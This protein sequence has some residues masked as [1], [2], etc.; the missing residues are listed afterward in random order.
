MKVFGYC[1]FLCGAFENFLTFCY[2]SSG[3]Y[4]GALGAN[5]LAKGLEGNKSL[6][7]CVLLNLAIF[8]VYFLLSA[9]HRSHY[10]L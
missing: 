3:N 2:H 1:I 9:S 5:A 7:V 8:Y 6:R 4:G 10:C